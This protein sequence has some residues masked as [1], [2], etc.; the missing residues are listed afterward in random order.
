[1][2]SI[3][4]ATEP[5][6]KI[7]VLNAPLDR[8]LYG[9]I[10]GCGT[11]F[12]GREHKRAVQYNDN[13]EWIGGVPDH[14]PAISRAMHKPLRLRPERTYGTFDEMLES[15]PSQ[16][17]A[18][19]W[20][21]IC[22]PNHLHFDQASAAIRAGWNTMLEKPM[23]HTVEQAQAL[24]DLVFKH[25]VV[26]GLTH[27]YFGHPMIRLIEKLIAD[28]KIGIAETVIGYYWQDWLRFLIEAEGQQQASWRTDKSKSGRLGCGGD[29]LTHIL[30]MVL[31]LTG[32]KPLKVRAD[33][34]TLVEGRKLDD[35]VFAD[36]SGIVGGKDPVEM[37]LM[38][39]QTMC[40]ELNN[41]GFRITG[42]KGTIIW[43]QEHPEEVILRQK[44]EADQVYRRNGGALW[45]TPEFQAD[46][47]IPGGHPEGYSRAEGNV[48]LRFQDDV[49]R[50]ASGAKFGQ[51]YGGAKINYPGV[52]DG[53]WGVSMINGVADS[54][55]GGGVWVNM[56]QPV[57]PEIAA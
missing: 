9:L 16:S 51:G 48:Y 19:D 23:C 37:H 3:D 4:G 54:H 35:N 41:F 32:A 20:I 27:T 39:S 25:Q 21:S 38:A 31:R 29:I 24:I 47:I 56:V 49:I 45:A 42:T 22:T 52:I 57:I 36:V 6:F 40:G 50:R 8:P 15:E 53:F 17:P 12:I 46:T 55:E 10:V 28:G 14:R 1:M 33:L 44:G 13:A 34:R 11:G 43:E 5:E 30:Q 18:A 7:P 26:F 2:P